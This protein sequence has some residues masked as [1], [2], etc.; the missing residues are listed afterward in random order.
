MPAEDK[1]FLRR[2]SS[3]KLEAM[4]AEEAPPSAAPASAGQD[5]PLELP[6][7]ES[8][9]PESEFR[10]FMDRR[11]DVATRNVALKKLF[12]DPR[13]NVI[14]EMDIDIDDYANLVKL[15]EA[16]VLNLSHARR[17]LFGP[18]PEPKEAP[19]SEEAEVALAQDASAPTDEPAQD[20]ASGEVD[21]AQLANPDEDDGTYV[22]GVPP[23]QVAHAP[24]PD[25]NRDV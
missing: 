8:L 15:T 5:Q 21:P 14:D 19:A 17:A 3:R 18:E 13:F 4:K 10:G 20:P 22:E 1:D 24:V 7:I 23:T 9:T 6:P 25:K 11:V 16:E 2:W 12:A